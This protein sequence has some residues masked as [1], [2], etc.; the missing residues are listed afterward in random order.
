MLPGRNKA[1][2]A[3]FPNS[4]LSAK[5]TADARLIPSPNKRTHAWASHVPQKN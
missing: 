2:P 3:P 4:F 5:Q 1:H